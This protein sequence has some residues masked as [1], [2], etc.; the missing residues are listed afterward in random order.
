MSDGEVI[1]EVGL[2]LAGVAPGVGG[3][4]VP[5]YEA[6]LRP[7]NAGIKSDLGLRKALTDRS[8]EGVMIGPVRDLVELLVSL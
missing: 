5:H 1:L 6:L 4:D 3:R 7:R 2:H 8:A